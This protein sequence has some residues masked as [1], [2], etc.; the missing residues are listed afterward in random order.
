MA[1]NI[2]NDN[3]ETDNERPH[4]H[5]KIY[6][7]VEIMTIMTTKT[8]Y[9]SAILYK[10]HVKCLVYYKQKQWTIFISLGLTMV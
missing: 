10:N 1:C 4:R 6:D 3:I 9:S 5:S 7:D 8:G 2:E